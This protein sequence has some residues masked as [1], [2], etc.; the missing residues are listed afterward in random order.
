MESIHATD[1]SFSA[2]TE[3]TLRRVRG[4]GSQTCGST[5]NTEGHP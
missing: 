3:G 5:T 1:G 2:P 4:S